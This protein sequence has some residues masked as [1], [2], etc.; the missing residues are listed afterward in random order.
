M[1]KIRYLN[2]RERIDEITPEDHRIGIDVLLIECKGEE[3]IGAVYGPFRSDVSMC[4]I[5]TRGCARMRINM[6]EH[7]V[8]SPCVLVVMSGQIYETIEHSED[9][10]ARA[11]V[12][13]DRF[14]QSLFP[15]S[16]LSHPA[17]SAINENPVLPLKNGSKVF[18]LFY[19]L[20]LD[21]ASSPSVTHSLDAAKYLTLTMFYGYGFDAHE[22]Q[23]NSNSGSKRQELLYARFL[24]L[25]KLHHKEER[26]VS[27]YADK[28]CIS[29]KY[30]YMIVKN[31][32]GHNVLD[33]IEDYVISEAKALLSSTNASI[34]EIA[35]ELN[36]PSQSVF[37]KYF[38]RV[39][40]M[41]PKSYRDT[42]R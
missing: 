18:D 21:L 20:M 15:N 42:F 2:W 25:I 19:S 6:Q 8:Q 31:T 13:S 4:L 7:T 29:P 40:G 22:I 1:K 36:F 12:M 34:Q 32:I 11:I 38:K 33:C 10:E 37:G 16:G 5:Y 23:E 26:E 14:V 35:Y 41:S 28:L 3:H 24:E 17:Y 9:I 39:T 30:L 27:F